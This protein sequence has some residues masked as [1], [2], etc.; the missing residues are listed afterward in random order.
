[1]NFKFGLEFPIA[2]IQVA[3]KRFLPLLVKNKL[4]NNDYDVDVL[5]PNHLT[6]N[7]K[8]KTVTMSSVRPLVLN[9]GSLKSSMGATTF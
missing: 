7:L 9:Q 6:Q 3:I 2:F 1:M 4:N 8:N 5:M